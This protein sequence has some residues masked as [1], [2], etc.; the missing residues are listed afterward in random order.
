L[1]QVR[2][3]LFHRLRTPPHD[4]T[5]LS[6]SQPL[7]GS[8]TKLLISSLTHSTSRPS[9]FCHIRSPCTV[10]VRNSL[11]SSLTH[12]TSRPSRFCHI[13]SPCTVQVR[14]SLISSL[15]HST[16]RTSFCHIRSPCS[17]STCQDLALTTHG[18]PFVQSAFTAPVSASP[19]TLIAGDA[20]LEYAMKYGHVESR[21]Q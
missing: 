2:N 21:A 12:S 6:H 7:Y 16:S 19:P 8:S 9:R 3:S 17:Y 18:Y 13:R 5:L 14:N 1:V 4:L 20:A 11:I 10:Q 15:T